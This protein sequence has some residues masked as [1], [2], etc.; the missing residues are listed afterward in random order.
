M[1]LSRG[2]TGMGDQ[3]SSCDDSRL[4]C[5]ETGPMFE[6]GLVLVVFATASNISCQHD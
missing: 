6:A 4:G 1:W 2:C 3:T 5:F